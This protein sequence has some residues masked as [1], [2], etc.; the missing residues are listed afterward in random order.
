M[1]ER[2]A[3]GEEEEA[4]KD[5]MLEEQRSQMRTTGFALAAMAGIVHGFEESSCARGL[6]LAVD[7]DETDC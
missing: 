1:Q 5:A 7:E 3:A 2:L 4:P 6:Q